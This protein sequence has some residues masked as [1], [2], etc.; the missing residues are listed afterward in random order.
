MIPMVFKG[1][2][3]KAPPSDI[4]KVIKKFLVKLFSKI[5]RKRLIF[6]KRLPPNNSVLFLQTI[7]KKHLYK[8]PACEDVCFFIYLQTVLT[9]VSI[10]NASRLRSM[11]DAMKS[12][13]KIME[14]VKRLVI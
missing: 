14:P 1:Y 7:P 4:L 13:S 5:F 8:N 3:E 9:I 12:Q 10:L 6:E 11:P 2:F